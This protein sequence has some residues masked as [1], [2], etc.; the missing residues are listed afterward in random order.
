MK[1]KK[2]CSNC[3]ME[4]RFLRREDIQLG[5]SGF[6]RGYLA[7]SD[8]RRLACGNLVLPRMR[9]AGFLPGPAG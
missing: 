6:F 3:G 4:L 2:V 5:K 9:E 7:Q 8:G 1:E